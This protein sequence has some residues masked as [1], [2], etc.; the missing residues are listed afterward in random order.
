MCMCIPVQTCK[1]TSVN[2]PSKLTGY[3]SDKNIGLLHSNGLLL[4]SIYGI[5]YATGTAHKNLTSNYCLQNKTVPMKI[6]QKISHI[7]YTVQYDNVCFIIIIHTYMC[8]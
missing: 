4:F 2:T 5:R 3:R 6:P 7:L 1:D 8:V